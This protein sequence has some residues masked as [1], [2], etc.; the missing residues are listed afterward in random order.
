MTAESGVK[1]LEGI[2]IDPDFEFQLLDEKRW[3]AHFNEILYEDV[4]KKYD[5]ASSHI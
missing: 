2:M 1:G 4:E 5:T 3:K